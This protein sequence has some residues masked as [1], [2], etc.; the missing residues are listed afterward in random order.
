M[1]A[2][3][4]ARGDGSGAG[5]VRSLGEALHD[6]GGQAATFTVAA[7]LALGLKTFYSRAGADDLDF[8]LAPTTGLVEAATGLAFEREPGVGF[9]SRDAVYL[10]APACAGLNFTIAA[11]AT[12]VLGFTP[13]RAP[14]FARAVRLVLFAVVALAVTPLANATRITLDLTFAPPDFLPLPDLSRAER[15]RIE[16]IVVYLVALWLL[17]AA[18]ERWLDLESAARTRIGLPLAVYL[19]VTVGLPLLNPLSPGPAPGSLWSHARVVLTTSLSL[20]FA[21][22]ALQ[23]LRA[24]PGRTPRPHRRRRLGTGSQTESSLPASPV[25]PDLC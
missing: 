16:G 4:E 11:F 15:H 23:W 7:C 17:H 10:I 9:L 25:S 21:L 5:V 13:R 3:G 19:T 22:A 8:V 12:L 18:A 2:P 1:H 14:L 24:A 20:A 6:R